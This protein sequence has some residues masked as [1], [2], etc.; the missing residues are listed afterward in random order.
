MASLF[1]LGGNKKQPIYMDPPSFP[2][3]NNTPM[4]A[5]HP[6]FY[7]PKTRNN[8]IRN[9][10]N[11]LTLKM[12]GTKNKTNKRLLSSRINRLKQAIGHPTESNGYE[13][14]AVNPANNGYLNT[15]Y[16]HRPAAAPP[17]FVAPYHNSGLATGPPSPYHALGRMYAYPNRNG[18]M[19]MSAKFPSG[20]MYAEPNRYGG[21]RKSRKSRKSRR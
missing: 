19:V 17:P 20:S 3:R 12:N 16:A 10:I 9:N 8:S 15:F 7:G 5:E 6:V 4:Y 1:S 14:W 21:T 18:K 2:R 13:G 11:K